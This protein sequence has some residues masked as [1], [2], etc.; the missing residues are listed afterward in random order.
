MLSVWQSE[1]FH[2]SCLMV[3]QDVWQRGYFGEIKEEAAA[4]SLPGTFAEIAP[5]P[6]DL[7]AIDK[8]L[9]ATTRR[10]PPPCRVA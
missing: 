6:S 3:G 2:H 1:P 8:E 7:H 10:S 9:S 5:L 4:P